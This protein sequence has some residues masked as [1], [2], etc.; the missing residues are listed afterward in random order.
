MAVLI[1][2]KIFFGELKHRRFLLLLQVAF[3]KCFFFFLGQPKCFYLEIFR[4]ADNRDT[5]Y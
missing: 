1:G 4:H 5:D 3:R 2:M